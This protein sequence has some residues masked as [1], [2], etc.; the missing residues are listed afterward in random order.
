M[1]KLISLVGAGALLL[2]VVAPVLA[3]SDHCDRCGGRRD[4]CCPVVQNENDVDVHADVD[5]DANTGDNRIEVERATVGHRGDLEIESG[6]ADALG[7]VLVENTNRVRA[8]RRS[9]PVVSE[10]DVDVRADVDVDANTGDNKIEGERA[11]VGVDV[12]IES[13]GAMASVYVTVTNANYIRVR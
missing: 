9:G 10:N 7:D 5:V 8:G 11:L 6:D 12:E 4:R 1:K 2:S 13:C 3:G